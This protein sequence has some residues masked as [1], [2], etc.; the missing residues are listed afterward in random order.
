MNEIATQPQPERRATQVE[1]YTA[2]VLG[3]DSRTA[4]LFRALPRHIP[5]ARFQRNLLNL[6]MQKPEMLQYDA[7]L[8]Y[9]EVSKA[10]ALGLLLDPQLG[11]GYIVPVWNAKANRRDPELRCGYRGLIKLARQSGD[12]AN[13]YPGAVHE[14]DHFLAD[15]GTEKRLEHQPDYTKPRGKPVC[16]Y[17]VVIYKDGT[18]DFEVMDMESIYEIRAKSDGWRAFQ[19]GKIKSTPWTT[20]EGEMCKKTVLRRLLKRVPQSPDLADALALDNE[21]L[22]SP[23]NVIDVPRAPRPVASIESR[24]DEFASDGEPDGQL[25]V[26][27]DAESAEPEPQAALPE[28]SA[29]SASS[30]P[31]TPAGQDGADATQLPD[32]IKDAVARGRGARRDGFQR[33]VPKGY[34]YKSRQEEADA[35]LRGWDD[36]NAKMNLDDFGAAE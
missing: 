36:E 20:D 2:Q 27:T 29:A 17:A 4:E 9:R 3:D 11:E 16:Y 10:A 24:L 28:V 12:I 18:K 25:P 6:I 5:P 7:R 30:E 19:A 23:V 26:A 8:V 32:K 21:P 31:A 13:L 1:I 34:H 35:F 15:E 22:N 14:R 33:D